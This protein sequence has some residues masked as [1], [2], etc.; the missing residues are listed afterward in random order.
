MQL[1]VV[2]QY[3][4][5]QS[6]EHFQRQATDYQLSSLW[7]QINILVT[8]VQDGVILR[9]PR[10]LPELKVYLLQTAWM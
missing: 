9:K 1:P 4:A 7:N 2:Q 6:F 5:A 8:N 10:N 3:S